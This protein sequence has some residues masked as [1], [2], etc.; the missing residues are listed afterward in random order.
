VLNT[1]TSAITGTRFIAVPGGGEVV[2]TA[3]GSAYNF[4]LTNQQATGVL[5]LDSTLTSPQWRQFTPYGA[6]RG[7]PPSAWPD[8][9]GFLG[10]PTDANTALTIIG[11]RQYDPTTSRFLSLDP[12]LDP[13]APQQLN[14]YSYA[15]GNPVTQSDPTG[16]CT[17]F[18]DCNGIPEPGSHKPGKTYRGGGQ[19]NPSNPSGYTP[20]PCPSY[21]YGCP[22]YSSYP[23]VHLSL[24]LNQITGPLPVLVHA[25]R[26]ANLWY[27][28]SSYAVG[29]SLASLYGCTGG[30]AV[31]GGCDPAQTIN[32][33]F[34]AGQICHQSGLSCH[35]GS[36]AQEWA[37]M[38]ASLALSF[39]MSCGGQSFT[40][41]TKVLLATKATIPISQIKPG[42]KVLATNI[43]TGKTTAQPVTTV[44]IHHDTNLYNLTIRTGRHTAVI[45]TTANHL[46][47]NPATHQWTKAAAMVGGTRLSSAD[48]TE[49]ATVR[50]QFASMRSGWMWD[51]TVTTDHDFYISGANSTILVHN[52]GGEGTVAG[53]TTAAFPPRTAY[54]YRLEDLEGNYL[55]TG[56]SEYPAGRYRAGFMSDKFMRILTSGHKPEIRNL[57]RYIVEIDPGPLNNEPWRGAQAGG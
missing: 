18:P 55:K 40:A 8:T 47:W 33:G 24:G 26:A 53:D 44:L 45:H 27:N 48:G 6:P 51:L 32:Q 4:E 19:N 41:A 17:Q 37:A 9:N 29:I 30:D 11:A 5:T 15:A 1:S 35:L 20:P 21:D 38:T 3:S 42:D 31:Q 14:G 12:V 57:E 22:G 46:F 43:A 28:N 54:L 36:S 13:S 34:L 10:K 16:L 49:A 56:M 23:Q 50:G 52:C 2:R 25:V 7:T 39:A